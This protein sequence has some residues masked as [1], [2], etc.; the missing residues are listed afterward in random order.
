MHELT[1]KFKD[2]FYF[3]AYELMVDDLRDY[4]FYKDDLIHPTS[5]AEN[6]IWENLPNA[7]FPGKL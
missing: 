4:R 5:M 7:T 1:E 3:P 6:Y 2:V